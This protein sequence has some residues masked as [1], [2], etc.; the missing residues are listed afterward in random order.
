MHCFLV[1]KLFYILEN[2]I[3][4]QL[5][6]GLLNAPITFMNLMNSV[7]QQY[8]DKSML[9]FLDDIL[10]YS[11]NEK[12]HNYHLRLALEVLRRNQ[13]YGKLSNVTYMFTKLS[14]WVISSLQKEF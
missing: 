2:I 9:V 12:E 11:K 14:I 8:L 7:Y 5:P 10:I 13:L 4:K 6:F 3:Y 1:S